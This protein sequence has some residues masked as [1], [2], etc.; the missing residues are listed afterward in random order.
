MVLL[1]T[2]V[3]WLRYEKNNV[4]NKSADKT[5]F[6]IDYE[7]KIIN[8]MTDMSRL[9]TTQEKK[10]IHQTHLQLTKIGCEKMYGTNLSN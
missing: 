1:H 2:C 7:D 9:D 3:A 10:G 5:A 6:I 4:Y 8:E